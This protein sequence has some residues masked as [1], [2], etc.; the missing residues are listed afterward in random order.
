MAAL[1][2]AAGPRL[3][4]A[5]PVSRSAGVGE[6][7]RVT[8][9][10]GL[11]SFGGPIA[12]LGYF[13]REYVERRRWIGEAHYADLVAL[14]QFLPG[15]ASSQVGMAVG[16]DRA[17]L[18]GGLAAWLGFTLPSALIMAGLGVGVAGGALPGGSWVDGL[19]LAAVAVVAHAVWSMARALAPDLPR[20]G[21]ALASAAVAS[22]GGDTLHAGRPHRRRRDGGAPV[23]AAPRGRREA[24][25]RPGRRARAS[26]RRAP[27]GRRRAGAV[28]PAPRRSAGPP[29]RDGRPLVAFADA[30]YRAGALVFGGGHVVLPLLEASVVEPG[31]VSEDAFLAGYGA[32]QALPGPI[33]AFAAFLGATA[34]GPVPGGIVGAVVATVAIFL[35]GG[36]LV[37]AALPSW[38]ALRARPRTRAAL[39]GVNA[40][41]V[42]ILA[43]ALIDPVARGG[44]TGPADVAV[45]AAGFAALLTGRVSPLAVV[46]GAVAATL[47]IRALGG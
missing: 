37:V 2:P 22:P 16:I 30:F 13:R 26:R 34:S 27:G 17:G 33:F 18:P 7:F 31:W 3:P 32:A 43:A 45:A 25:A 1:P 9:R 21:L 35:P 5:A 12:H 23:P 44:V 38:H 39:A 42:G 40:A 10:L 47:V 15:P 46:A 6:V 29:P 28:P 14:G 36:L 20:A 41:V 4:A 11:T 19:K 8:L 24:A